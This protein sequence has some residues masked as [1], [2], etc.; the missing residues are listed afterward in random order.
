MATNNDIIVS[1]LTSKLVSKVFED[2]DPIMATVN[3]DYVGQFSPVSRYYT[4]GDT[5]Q[6]KLPGFQAV[7]RGLSVTPAAID[8]LKVSYTLD[9]T[10]DLYNVTNE[11]D[12]VYEQTDLGGIKEYATYYASQVYMSMSAEI[13]REAG[14]RMQNAAFLTP[15]DS[16]A[17]FTAINN[18]D[19]I[20]ETESMM[21]LLKFTRT[22]RVMMMNNYDSRYLANSM[23]NYFNEVLNSKILKEAR[24]GGPDKGRLAGLDLFRSADL[25]TH[26]AGVNGG[27]QTGVNGFTGAVS[28]T[29][30][31]GTTI[32]FKLFGLSQTPAIKAGDRIAIP[33]VK[34]L[35]PI[36]KQ[37]LDYNLVVTAAADANSDGSGNVTVTLS[38]P[39][40]VSGNHANVDALPANGDSIEI[41]PDYR[42]NF[43]YIPAGLSCV[44]LQMAPIRGAVNQKVDGKVPKCPV[45]VTIQGSNQSG[46]NIFRTSMFNAMKAFAPYILAVPGKIS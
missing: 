25:Y 11:F 37:A 30:V 38:H 42:L 13:A 5:I 36:S 7:T 6:I 8:D 23:Q 33:A 4:S 15:I 44:P 26:T 39:L 27:K 45:Q 34:V 1:T 28:S 29:S 22:G 46:Q 19:V 3:M 31:D 18:Y 43:A 9:K 35:Q 17:K 10:V 2:H 20:S 14:I 12:M 16:L 24:I 40:I 41:F 32:T 21:E